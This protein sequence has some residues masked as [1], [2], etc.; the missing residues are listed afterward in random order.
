[1]FSAEQA[2]AKILEGMAQAKGYTDIFAEGFLKVTDGIGTGVERV[3]NSATQHLGVVGQFISSIGADLLRLVS[4]R[5][6][7]QLLDFFMG[8]ALTGTRSGGVSGAGAGG[9]GGATGA[10]GVG[11]LGGIVTGIA[12]GFLTPGF[13]GGYPNIGTGSSGGGTIGLPYLGQLPVP[14][15][16]SA[17]NGKVEIPGAGAGALSLS[18]IGKQI[19]ALAPFL[20][21]G[22]GAALGGKSTLGGLLGGIG[23]ALG[24]LVGAAS[25]GAIGGTLGS[26]FAL[27]GALGPAALIAAPLLI[28][29]GLLLGKA[30]QRREDER[31]ADTYWVAYKDTLIDLTRQVRSNS[32]DG[33]DAL[34][35]AQAARQQAISQI[36]T[37]Q[38]KS[39]RES[40]LKNQIGDVDRMFLEPLKQAVND[41]KSRNSLS[42]KLIPEFAASGI[43]PGPLGSP[44]LVL[45]HGG[46]IFINRDKQTTQVMSAASDAGVPGVS[47]MRGS[48]AQGRGDAPIHVTL[49]VGKKMQNEMFKNGA[50]SQEGYTA[51]V[52]AGKKQARFR[53]I[54]F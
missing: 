46:E 5:L 38:T 23:G 6:L 13:N 9:Y 31:T 49:V 43:V 15:L 26:A 34:A 10:T 21:F 54:D 20:G 40:R 32:I 8:G 11:G 36:N 4:N 24:G 17:I 44:Q 25:V 35:Q 12:G 50:K 2:R 39:V 3:L 1:V 27:S 14:L 37:I 53:D 48:A 52:D 22:A 29:G 42:S 18:G 51:L 33:D 28:V 7:V 45:A 19:G 30:K 16:Q 41:Q 47:A